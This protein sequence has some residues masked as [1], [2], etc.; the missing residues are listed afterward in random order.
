MPTT[1]STNRR[2][3][4]GLLGASLATG[5]APW[6]VHTQAQAQA[7]SLIHISGAMRL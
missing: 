1:H 4:L 3:A 6:C 2:R 7:L 5:V